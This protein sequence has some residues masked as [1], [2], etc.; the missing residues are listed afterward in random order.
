MPQA[1]PIL[2]QAQPGFWKSWNLELKKC[3]IQRTYEKKK[4]LKIQIHV[5]PKIAGSGSVET[6][7]QYFFGSCICF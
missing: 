3:G 5:P 1:W 6:H 4:I 2:A 7:A